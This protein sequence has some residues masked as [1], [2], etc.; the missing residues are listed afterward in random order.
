[1][2]K[3]VFQPGEYVTREGKRARVYAVDGRP[4]Y[5]L[6]GAILTD[7]GWMPLS[8]TKHGRQVTSATGHLDLMSPKRVRYVNVYRSPSSDHLGDDHATRGAADR[9]ATPARI[10]C[11]RIEYSEG[12]YDE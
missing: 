2:S 4:D 7:T 9:R 12:Q 1:M 6:R 11:I 3:T 10:A 8:W 5:P